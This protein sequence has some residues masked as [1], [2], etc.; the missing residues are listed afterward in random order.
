MNLP[1]MLPFGQSLAFDPFALD[2][3]GM[4][5]FFHMYPVQMRQP[6]KSPKKHRPVPRGRRRGDTSVTP[7]KPFRPVLIEE[8][9]REE[10][11]LEEQESSRDVVSPFATQLDE[12]ARNAAAHRDQGT[13]NHAHRGYATMPPRSGRPIRNVGNGLYD[14]IGRGRLRAVGIPMEATAP[15]P[16]PIAPLGRTEHARYAI[17]PTQDGCGVVDI[18]RAAEW[19]GK[20]CNTC[21]PDH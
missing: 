2:N 10:G 19:V 9:P 8:T 11:K 17:E 15:F 13:S 20:A 16:D 4:P 21:E 3:Y 5:W 12:I 14:T 1:W 7:K 18:D 6:W